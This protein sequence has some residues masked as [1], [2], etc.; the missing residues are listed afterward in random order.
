MTAI[1]ASTVHTEEQFVGDLT[2]VALRVA[3]R[4]GLRGSSVD[5]E[6]E[7]WKALGEVVR[8]QERAARRGRA[9]KVNFVARLTD[10]AYGVALGHG[11]MGSFV[12]VELDLWTA[13]GRVVR[14]SR[15]PR[16]A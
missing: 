14:Q 4:H 15:E 12:D 13:L 11:F 16:V 2:D 5:H 10:A 8:E 7:L 9:D 1:E 6:V 3:E